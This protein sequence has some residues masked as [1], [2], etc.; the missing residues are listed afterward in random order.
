MK[1]TKT[2]AHPINGERCQVCPD[3][4]G[5]KRLPC[6]CVPRDVPV[7]EMVSDPGCQV[8]GGEGDNWCARCA[9][10]G[11][12]LCDQ[13]EIT[14]DE[15]L[16]R[17]QIAAIKIPGLDVMEKDVADPVDVEKYIR[18]LPMDS[19]S[20]RERTLVAGNIRGFAMEVRQA[21]K[22]NGPGNLEPCPECGRSCTCP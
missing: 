6:E 7:E 1:Q 10:T 15:D 13:D 22:D 14:I 16:L 9:G 21:C 4:G 20:D 18:E 17:E 12:V 8:C 3:C 11:A 2:N 5:N 19:L